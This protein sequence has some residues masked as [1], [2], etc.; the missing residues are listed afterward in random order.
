MIKE[1]IFFNNIRITVYDDGTATA[2]GV[3]LPDQNRDCTHIVMSEMPSDKDNVSVPRPY[4]LKRK[5]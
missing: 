4:R 5:D 2:T 3:L 1:E